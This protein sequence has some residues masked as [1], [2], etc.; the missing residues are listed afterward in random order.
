[1]TFT[2][3][4]HLDV[5]QMSS[6]K[7]QCFRWL[8]PQ[9]IGRRLDTGR[10]TLAFKSESDLLLHSYSASSNTFFITHI[11]S[12]VRAAVS[13]YKDVL[14]NKKTFTKKFYQPFY[15]PNEPLMFATNVKR[16]N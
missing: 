7:D 16:N 3:G 2:K 14:R 1:M 10:M 11:N 8:I 9:Q 6:E 13:L 5:I 4:P 15:K 12:I